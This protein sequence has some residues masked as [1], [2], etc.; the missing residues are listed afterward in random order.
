MGSGSGFLSSVNWFFWYFKQ[1]FIGCWRGDK[2]SPCAFS[3]R[4]SLKWNLSMERVRQNRGRIVD[5]IA[6]DSHVELIQSVFFLP[7]NSYHQRDEESTAENPGGE[8]EREEDLCQN[9]LLI[10]Q[11]LI[12]VINNGSYIYT[13]SGALRRGGCNQENMCSII[14]WQVLLFVFTNQHISHCLYCVWGNNRLNSDK[15][16]YCN[17]L[18][19]VV[20]WLG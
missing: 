12:T 1:P 5:I 8:G 18:F 9:V 3:S 6:F 15:C 19:S 20:V 10:M 13:G 11:L 17:E 7:F 2:S 14:S 16:L 4:R